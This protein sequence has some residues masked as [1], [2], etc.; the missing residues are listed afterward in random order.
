MSRTGRHIGLELAETAVHYGAAARLAR[1][2]GLL[3]EQLAEALAEGDRER[4]SQLNAALARL[5]VRQGGGDG[6]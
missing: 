3:E 2:R 4:V 5:V 6:D 1:R